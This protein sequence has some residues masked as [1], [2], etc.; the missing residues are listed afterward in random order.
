MIKK[1]RVEDMLAESLK[2]LVQTK[3]FYKITVQDIASNCNLT[4]TTFYRHFQDKYELMN[5][6]YLDMSLQFKERHC[7]GYRWEDFLMF[8]ISFI[9]ENQTYFQSIIPMNGQNSFHQFWIE[10]GEKN[11]IKLIRQKLAKKD[12]PEEVMLQV[13]FYHA[14]VYALMSDWVM[15]GCKIETKSLVSILVQ[16][17]PAELHR[18]LD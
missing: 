3:P 1:R 14:G 2:E 11:C 5:W 17:M 16:C 18:Y 4:R 6:I 13:R 10:N 15:E 12:L 9:E 8:C 7:C